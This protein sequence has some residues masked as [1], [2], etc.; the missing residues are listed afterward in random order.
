MTQVQEFDKIIPIEIDIEKLQTLFNQVVIEFNPTENEKTASGIYTPAKSTVDSRAEHANRMGTVV[1]VPKYL[2]FKKED[3]SHSMRWKTDIQIEPGDKVWANFTTINDFQYRANGKYYKTVNYEDL[4]VAKRGNRVITLNG[5]LLIEPYYFTRKVLDY[6]KKFIDMTK[7]TIAY[8]GKE[9]QDY[10]SVENT[11]MG[12]SVYRKDVK[13]Y[14]AGDKV[15]FN[16]KAVKK[17][18]PLEYSAYNKFDGKTY[19]VAQRHMIVGTVDK[20]S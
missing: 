8:L 15:I 13:G 16:H 10:T 3:H 11:Y 12:K 1:T 19:F 18:R 6:E 20:F 4:V 17:L 14:K 2:Y 5:Y 9:N 7:G